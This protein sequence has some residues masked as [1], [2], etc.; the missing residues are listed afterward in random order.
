MF[1]FL[2]CFNDS[3][4]G[5][6]LQIGRIGSRQAA[7]YR[8]LHQTQSAGVIFEKRSACDFSRSKESADHIAA[9]VFDLTFFRN[10]DD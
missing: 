5:S 6:P 7:V 10:A 2:R 9:G 1:H 4:R 3:M 8:A